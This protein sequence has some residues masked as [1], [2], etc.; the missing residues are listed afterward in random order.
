[1]QTMTN[2]RNTNKQTKVITK[3]H[4]LCLSIHTSYIKQADKIIKVNTTSKF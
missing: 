1:M 4:N 3:H 2:K